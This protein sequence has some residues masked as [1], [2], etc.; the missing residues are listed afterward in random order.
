[1]ITVI[2]GTHRPKNITRKIV[3]KYCQML[4]SAGQEIRLFELEEL[5]RDF[6]FGDSFGNRSPVTEAIIKDKI[7][8]AD[9]LV[10][11]SPEYNGSYPGVLKAFM[12]GMDPRLWKGKKVALVGVASGRAGNIRGM[13]HLTHVL[14]YLRM[15][16]FSNKVPISKVNGL[17]NDQGELV[18]TETLLV[19]QRQLDEF[20]E[21]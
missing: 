17:L 1:M 11:I 21:Y 3:D 13:D 5:P 15:E 2:C 7:I 16:V 14:H 20:L 12:D 10:I 8:P 19:L 6:V 9:K 18:D 4:R